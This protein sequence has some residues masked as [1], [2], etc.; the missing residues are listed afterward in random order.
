MGIAER[1]QRQREEIRA[2][3][4][5]AA[6]HLV[7]EE[8]WAALSIRKIAEAIEYSVPVV[9]DHFE[10]KDA[11][12]AEFNKKGFQLL[13]NQL[14]TARQQHTD[15]EQQLEAIGRA[16]WDFAFQH[17][18]YYQ[19]MFSLGIPTCESARKIPEVGECMDV[20]RCTI[21]HIIKQNGNG[22]ADP[23]LKF[24]AFQSMIHGLVSINI[25]GPANNEELNRLVL[26]DLISGFIKGCKA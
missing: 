5:D 13:E 7:H 9:Y 11:I 23:F 10:N 14:R 8:G 1:K 16:Y 6:W 17:K 22:A 2:G 24:Q 26:Q 25:I 21:E 20:I 3:I 18:Q 12:I 15:A 4:L 19:L